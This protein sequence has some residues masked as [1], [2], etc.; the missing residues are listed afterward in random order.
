MVNLDPTTGSEIQKSRPVV[1]TSFD[2]V[3]KLPIRL[4]APLT[5]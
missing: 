1:V 5:E 4:P 3:G 2:A